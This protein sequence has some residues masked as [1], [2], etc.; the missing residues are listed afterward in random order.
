[1]RTEIL[2][3]VQN[4]LVRGIDR[5]KPYTQTDTG[6]IYPSRHIYIKIEKYLKEFLGRGRENRWII[7]P[8]LR[9]V[10]KTTV[11]A[12]L[13]LNY[14]N[15][16][17]SK[18]FLYISLDD[19][20]PIFNSSLKEV[21][22]A[23]EYILGN[24][25]ESQKEPVFLFIDEVQQDIKWA[26]TLKSLHDKARNI[27]IICS[28][29]SA[30]SLQTNPD[31]A[32]R[33]IFEKLYP[34]SFGEYEMIKRNIFPPGG[35]KQK[36]KTG[37]YESASAEDAYS[38]LQVLGKEVAAQW[39]KFDRLD[40]DEFLNTGT[41]PFAIRTK[42]P[43]RVY[44]S[45][46]NVLEKIISKDIQG[47]GKFDSPTLNSIKRLL[48]I[49]ADTDV[50]SVNNISGAMGIGNITL[51]NVL[52]TLEK[53]ELVIK[54]PA[55]GSN[56]VGVR[57]PAKYLFMSPAIR[58]SLLTITGLEGTLASRKGRLLEDLVGLHFYREFIAPGNGFLTYDSAKEGADFILQIANKK[59]M[60]VEVGVGEKGI[61]QV[62]NTMEKIK[63]N[64]GLVLCTDELSLFKK[65]NIIKVPLTYF[66]LI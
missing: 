4:Q 54:V 48:F 23:Y 13:Y 63:C 44:E 66:L 64:F 28:G 36:I 15:K 50:V 53:T 8:G 61:K 34:L 2:T 41:L 55:H 29:S 39:A 17:D 20:V 7:V 14:K 27:F 37:I 12:Q 56:I 1:M 30:V 31:V 49:M 11:L 33:A 60:A 58:M 35:L 25:F 22:E 10:G 5:L 43:M 21:L 24:S 46:N 18:H 62:Q 9:G 45:I 32:R 6:F 19:V 26:A 65:E 40:I 42:D 51:T 57:K 52:D 3:Y 16:I 59:Q 47:L 38:K